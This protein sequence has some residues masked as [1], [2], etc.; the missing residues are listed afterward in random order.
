MSAMRPERERRNVEAG[1]VVLGT[2]GDLEAKRKRR[3]R[4]CVRVREE[5]VRGGVSVRGSRNGGV[6]VILQNKVI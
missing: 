4:L 3:W 1:G 2:G 6:V 5:A